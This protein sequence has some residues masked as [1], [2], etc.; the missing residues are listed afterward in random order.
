M[1]QIKKAYRKKALECHP[2]KNPDNPKAAELFHE[3]SKAL[4]ILV[5]ASARAAYDRVLTAKKAA[6]LRLREL[7]S[8]RQKLIEDL[9]RREKE[10]ERRAKGNKTY[11]D[12]T[13]EER[14]QEEIKRLRTEGSKLLEEEQERMRRH[15][16]AEADRLSSYTPLWNSSENRIKINWTASKDD[17]TNGGY[18]EEILRQFLK[19]YGDVTVLILSSKKKGSALVEFATKEASEM[20]LE[21]EKGI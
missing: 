18:S 8:K 10:A 15:I 16:F 21:L 14:L 12:R 19:K 5:D 13:D 11:D 1:F 6:K 2:D 9:E 17:K 3:L 7:D 4:E 20:A